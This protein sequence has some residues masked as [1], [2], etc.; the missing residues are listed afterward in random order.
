MRERFDPNRFALEPG[1]RLLEASAGTGKTFALAHLVLRYLSEA[2]LRLAD[3]LVVTYT[4]AAAAELRDRIGQR[5]QQALACLEDPQ[6]RAA[7]PTLE[8]WL[9]WARPQAQALRVPLLLALE[10]L[11]NA[12]ITTIHGFCRRTLQ[13]QAL[14]AA[15]PPD[16]QLD[17]DSP[18]LARL[19]AH[20]YWQQQVLALPVHLLAGVRRQLKGPQALEPLLVNLDG[21]P[22]LQ[23]EPLPPGCDGTA[24][25]A[26]QLEAHWA[27]A[28][29]R[30]GQ[31]WAERGEALEHDLCAAAV[32]W[33]AI[34]PGGKTAPYSAK[35]RRN[36]CAELDAWLAQQ[37]PGG[38]HGACVSHELLG[39]YFHPGCFTKVARSAGAE[40]SPS[41]P[42][43]PLLAAVAQICEAPAELTLLHACHW[44]RQQLTQRRRRA[45]SLGYGQLLEAL[46]PGAQPTTAVLEAVGRR[47]RAAL[48]DEFQ[49]TDPVQWRIVQGAFDP[50]RHALVLVGDPKQA[51]YR[52]RGGELAT[53]RRARGQAGSIVDLQVNYRTT[54]DLI[55]AFNALMGPGLRRSDLEVP[56][57]SA[58]ADQPPLPA[59]APLQ[60]VWLGGDRAAAEKPPSR[61]ALEAR[62]QALIANSSAALLQRGVPPQDVC[63]LVSTHVQAEGLRQAL[64][65]RGIASRLVS[66]GDVFETPAAAALQRLLDALADPGRASRLRLLAASPLLGWSAE[67]IATADPEQW[68]ALAA[69]LASASAQ[70]RGSGLL[71]ILAELLQERGLAQLALSGRLLADMQQC[72]ALVQERIHAEQ[73]GPAAAADWLRRL[74]LEPDRV[75][76]EAHQPNSDAVDAA[77]AV[78]TVHRSKGL[79]YPVVICPYLWQAPAAERGRGRLGV[80]WQPQPG[81]DPVFDLHLNR[82]WGPGLAARLQQRD[83]ELAERERLAYVA[84]TRARQLLVLAWGPAEQQQGN[85]LHPW[86][87][88]REAPPDP[89]H[90]PYG[91]RGDADWLALLQQEIAARALPLQLVLPPPPEPPLRWQPPAPGGRALQLGPV[92]QR[93]LDSLW[94]RSSYTSWTRGSHG[95]AA[96]ALEEGRETDALVTELELEADADPSLARDGPLAQFPRGAQAGDCLHRILEQL[97]FQ[98]PAEQQ[99]ELLQRELARS[100][101]DLAQAEPLAAGLQA[102]LHTPLGS[103]LGGLQLA[104]LPPQRRL[105]EMGFDLPLALLRAPQLARVFSDHPKGPFGAD[106]GAS[107]AQLPIASRG[108]VTGSIDLLFEHGQRWWVLDWKSNWLGER[109]AAGRPLHCGPRHYTPAAMTALMAANH[110]PLQAHLYLVALHRYLRWRLPG[111][112]PEQHLGGYAYVFVR[113][114]PG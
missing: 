107:L 95:A 111:Y 9:A 68:A 13:R 31:L 88:S 23:L 101:I 14:E 73:L 7:D 37:P 5:L 55:A 106:Y 11:D 49:D 82:H 91:A 109:D 32:Q 56:A 2:R 104:Q 3:M 38:D 50:A 22:A 15:Q 69:Q 79:E 114:V 58:G 89:D 97:D 105:H 62:T 24:A 57:V 74:R 81:G 63:L 25:L 70:L 92:P 6:R 98:R 65:Q 41:L 33:R 61:T 87:F 75:V 40:A 102:L 28:W 36:R 12:D 85:P 21:D 100:G 99:Q 71:T 112:A 8:V 90:D 76:P 78:V 39:G 93:A 77:V 110:Y 59:E 94:G 96:V 43:A 60:L 27:E 113:G 42:Q 53:Y 4:E 52:F 35:P 44:G 48:I 47:Y 17:P 86:L 103:G 108:F 80:R 72:A 84:L 45:G 19:I 46:D 29:A 64:E 67:R 26:P 16:L 20:D 10:E 18:R 54:P 83:A 30:F 66:A 34:A 51:I 1:L